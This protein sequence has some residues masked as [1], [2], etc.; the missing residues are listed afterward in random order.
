MLNMHIMSAI[1]TSSADCELSVVVGASSF[2]G[3]GGLSVL[4]GVFTSWLETELCNPM[5][6][7]M[8]L[9]YS[10]LDNLLLTSSTCNVSYTL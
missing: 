5:I 1:V 6:V 7:Y 2:L 9:G 4:S 10:N 8:T 3:G